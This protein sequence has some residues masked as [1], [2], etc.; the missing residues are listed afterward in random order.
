M[1]KLILT[2]CWVIGI[3]TFSFTVYKMKKVIKDFEERVINSQNESDKD[4]YRTYISKYNMVVRVMY[5]AMAFIT[6]VVLFL[7]ALLR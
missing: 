4:I 7:P 2:I 5:A 3:G 6:L 1:I